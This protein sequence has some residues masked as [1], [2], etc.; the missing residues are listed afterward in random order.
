MIDHRTAE[1]L[2]AA[3]IDFPLSH[4]EQTAL[5]AHLAGCDRCRT[6]GAQL[7]RHSLV[8]GEMATEGAPMRIR[9]AV[10]AAALQAGAT[11]Q[12]FMLLLAAALL[13]A[14]AIGGAIVVGSG[15]LDLDDLSINPSL[16]SPS[17]APSEAPALP[18]ALPTSGF[19]LVT[20]SELTVR[21]DPQS[22]AAQVGS[23]QQG[24]V[25]SILEGQTAA[26]G[27]VWYRVR[28]GELI[29][30]ATARDRSTEWIGE[31]PEP[32]SAWVLRVQRQYPTGALNDMTVVL[33]PDGRL[34]SPGLSVVSPGPVW[35]QRR[36]TNEGTRLFSQ[37]A[38]NSGLLEASAAYETEPPGYE[39]GYVHWSIS[40]V[41][42]QGPVMVAAR[43]SSDAPE[44]AGIV[45]LA[46]RLTA[47]AVDPPTA[48]LVDPDRGPAAYEPLTYDLVM[49]PRV[50]SL[51]DFGPMGLLGDADV[52]TVDLPLPTSVLDI[53][54]E[55]LDEPVPAGVRCASLTRDE[56]RALRE[57]FYA[58]GLD[59]GE[60]D[61]SVVFVQ[62]PWAAQSGVVQLVLKAVP[63]GVESCVNVLGGT[64]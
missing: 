64:G 5:D 29:G 4:D 45:A 21:T 32:S 38:V 42:E 23:L 18:P 48:W 26:D 39:G 16:P 55:V 12:R 2:M 43:T 62:L 10:E 47:L 24:D 8:L 30:W 40:V 51:S 7:R 52:D 31:L 37:E 57:A 59:R 63:P 20:A 36:L 34:V 14:A 61:A 11:N 35:E 3:A 13:A 44:A 50:G 56:A 46:E 58:L 17:A 54:E 49:T 33:Y 1:G 53:G 41:A 22:D 15:M 60:Q 27:L 28:L 19:A 25:V 6:V 9:G